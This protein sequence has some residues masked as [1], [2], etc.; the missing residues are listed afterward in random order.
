MS[1]TRAG[2]DTIVCNEATEE[3]YMEGIGWY[4]SEIQRKVYFIQIDGEIRD[5]GVRISAASRI[6]YDNS[7]LLLLNSA[8]P[9]SEMVFYAYGRGRLLGIFPE[10]YQAVNVSYDLMGMVTDQY[11]RILW[12]R[13]NRGNLRNLKDPQTSAYDILRHLND[14]SGNMEFDDSMVLLD[15]RGADLR[16]VLYFIGQ[17]Y[18]VLA[19]VENGGYLLLCG[20]DQYNVSIFNPVTEET[21]KMGLNDAADY[22]AGEGNDFV[23]GIHVK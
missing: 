1:K 18:P 7:E 9:D 15:A 6:S 2:N 17:G 11:Q 5:R 20:Y 23:C 12:D 8:A 21:H 3:A 22:F 19:Y 16:Q 10:F 14:F 4:A 13:V